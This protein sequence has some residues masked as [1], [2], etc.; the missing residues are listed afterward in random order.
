MRNILIIIP[1]LN[2]FKNIG[3]IYKKITKRHKNI[4]ILFVDDNSY[5]GSKQEI[6]DLRKNNKRIHYIFRHKKLGIG[7]AH[8]V[9]IKWAKKKKYQYV[10][11]MDCDG[12]HDP[13]YIKPMFKFIKN[14]NIVITNRF[15][16]KNS[17]IGWGYKRVFITKMRYYLILF[18]LGSK[19]DGSGAFRLYD[20][21]TVNL[22]DIMMSK[23]NNYNFFWES[24]FLL[25]RKYKIYQLPIKLRNRSLGSSKMQ[26]KD[27]VGGLFYL[28][29]IFINFK[30]NK[31]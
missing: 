28:F 26:F 19:L 1:T 29:K 2:E 24:A 31:I 27:I 20:L 15:L 4:N 25:E 21:K 18:L 9:A 13:K 5:D 10:Y 7:S 3:I 12:S 23:D 16:F 6:I 14:N 22:K 17:L 30:L 11:T 8:K